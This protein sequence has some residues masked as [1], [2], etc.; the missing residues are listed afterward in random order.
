AVALTS[1][2]VIMAG[3]GA[4]GTTASSRAST[5]AKDMPERIVGAPKDALSAASPQQDGS[6]WLLA[7]GAS[8]GMYKVKLATGHVTSSFSVSGAGRSVAESSTGILALGI[9]TST[10]G[11]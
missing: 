7:G 5:A 3:C 11:A 4:S 1:A 8:A 2:A 6:D 9:A 10:A